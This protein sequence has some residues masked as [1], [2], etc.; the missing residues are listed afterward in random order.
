M[1]RLALL[2]PVLVGAVACSDYDMAADGAQDTAFPAD[3]GDFAGSLRLD[4]QATSP[5]VGVGD[6]AYLPQS[7]PIDRE[8]TGDLDLELQA[9]VALLGRLSG[10]DLTPYAIVDLPGSAVAIDDA[11]VTLTLPG[12]VQAVVA[13]TNSAEDDVPAAAIGQYSALVVPGD[14]YVARFVP[15]DPTI[16][17]RTMLLDLDTDQTLDVD[18]G[19]GTAV[20]GDVRDPGGQPLPGVAV[21]AIDSL[22]TEGAVA[23]TDASGAYELRVDPGSYTIA[24][25][26]R[27][28]GRDPSIRAVAVNVGEAGATVDFDYPNLTLV[29][30]GGRVVDES[31]RG[32]PGIQA[33]FTTTSL[34][35]YDGSAS[36]SVEVVTDDSGNYDTRLIAG[37]WSLELLPG[38]TQPYTATRITDVAVGASALD[39]GATTLVGLG[40]LDG[41]VVDATDTPVADAQV[42]VIEQ[43]FG[44]RIWR[45][46]ADATGAFTVAAPQGPVDVLL[47]PPATRAGDL[48]L[49]RIPVGD[50]AADAAPLLTFTTGALVAGV[51][52][53]RVA[54]HRDHPAALAVVTAVDDAGRTVGV[55]LADGDGQFAMPVAW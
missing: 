5:L 4:V 16:P 41:T 55:T 52:H 10:Y 12:T 28:N 11:S 23:Y 43:G 32:V 19:H 51:V 21:H 20:W 50:A 40:V 45:A 7:F 3:S 14:G 37:D 29:P 34:A 24:C 31:G 15:G 2:V 39:F 27:G 54:A 9:P 53:F 18:L 35:G 13:S 38:D 30:V 49:T 44:G 47:T 25:D 8:A 46:T 1:R 42:E 17:F 26:G 36:L 22:G 48:A 6:R 33:R